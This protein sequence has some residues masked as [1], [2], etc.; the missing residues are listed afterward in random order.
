MS[1]I[2]LVP[3]EHDDD[4]AVGEVAQ[5]FQPLLRVLERGVVGYVVHE[6]GTNRAP[7]VT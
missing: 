3:H 6:Q 7:V 4:V 5:L 1:Q 2:R